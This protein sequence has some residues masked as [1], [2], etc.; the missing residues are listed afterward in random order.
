MDTS[1]NASSDFSIIQSE[2][3]F[4]QNI[5]EF[6]SPAKSASNSSFDV[7]GGI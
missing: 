4:E 7:Q 6:D 3:I 1:L 2:N 5:S